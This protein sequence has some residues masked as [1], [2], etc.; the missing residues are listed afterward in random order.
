MVTRT[1]KKK[2]VAEKKAPRKAPARKKKAAPRRAAAEPRTVAISLPSITID[3]SQ[4]PRIR[5]MIQ[6]KYAMNPRQLARTGGTDPILSLTDAQLYRKYVIDVLQ[7]DVAAYEAR[8][9]HQNADAGLA[10]PPNMS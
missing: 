2:P 6:A 9:A 7:R 10:S 3:D 5:A 4:V 1:M 8:L